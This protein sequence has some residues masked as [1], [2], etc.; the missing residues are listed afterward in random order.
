MEPKVPDPF[1][2]NFS[3]FFSAIHIAEEKEIRSKP[4]IE[5]MVKRKTGLIKILCL[6]TGM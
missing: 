5:H 4:K 3:K 6:L 1:M 2:H